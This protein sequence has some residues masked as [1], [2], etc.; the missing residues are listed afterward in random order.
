MVIGG[1]A[2]GYYPKRVSLVFMELLNF[3]ATVILVTASGALAPGP[4]F[5]AN[6]SRGATSGAKSGLVFSVAHT[7]VEFT[8]V[9]LLALG[10]V[11]FAS[12]ST[13]KVAIGIVGGTVL[14]LSVYFRFT[15][16]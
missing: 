2:E 13:V 12:E 9:M 4:L 7:V 5:F 14:V 10:L 6:L 15:A 16:L 8:L 11:T 3:V 1:L